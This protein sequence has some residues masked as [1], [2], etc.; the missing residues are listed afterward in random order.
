MKLKKMMAVVA[1]ILDG[2]YFFIDKV[3]KKVESE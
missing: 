2:E 1:I 3:G